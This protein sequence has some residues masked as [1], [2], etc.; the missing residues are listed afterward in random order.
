M[1][2]PHKAH[3]R[4]NCHGTRPSCPLGNTGCIVASHVLH[5]FR[6][7]LLEHGGMQHSASAVALSITEW[8]TGL[9]DNCVQAIP[10]QYLHERIPPISRRH[11]DLAFADCPCQM[12]VT[13]N[14][15][16][17]L[18]SVM[19]P[20][21][22]CTGTAAI[23]PQQIIATLPLGHPYLRLISPPRA[24]TVGL[25]PNAQLVPRLLEGACQS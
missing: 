15:A 8:L 12:Q 3:A 7:L 9:Y 24:H 17:T 20:D 5:Q 22:I 23:A 10:N 2:T 14:D 11:V 18:Q 19:L 25:H 16:V 21:L 6:R 13:N 1:L 4:S